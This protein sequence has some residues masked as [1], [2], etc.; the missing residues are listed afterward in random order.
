[1]QSAIAKYVVDV[2]AGQFPTIEHQY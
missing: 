2:K 1:I